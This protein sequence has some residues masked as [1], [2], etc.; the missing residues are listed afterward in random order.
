VRNTVLPFTESGR[1]NGAVPGWQAA[2]AGVVM[3]SLAPSSGIPPLASSIASPVPASLFSHAQLATFQ[4]EPGAH[5]W[6][7]GQVS[8]GGVTFGGHWQ[9][10]PTQICKP[11]LVVQVL[12]D[13]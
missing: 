12:F 3:A 2:S 7:R 1:Q 4:V 5:V 9:T 8:H 6:L 13:T 11:S 10:P